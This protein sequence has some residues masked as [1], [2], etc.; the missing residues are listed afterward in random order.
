M[1][2]VSGAGAAGGPP[3]ARIN[4]AISQYGVSDTSNLGQDV[5]ALLNVTVNAQTALDNLQR[6]GHSIAGGG[7]GVSSSPGAFSQGGIDMSGWDA[8]FDEAASVGASLDS[9]ESEAMNLMKSPKKEDQIKGQQMMQA[10]SQ[11]MEA[12][13]KAIQARGDA[14]KHAIQG[15]E[16]H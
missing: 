8:K 9:M 16:S 15:S 13:I 7:G 5:R 3:S 10:V 14:A 6:A 11:I 12:I 1:A 2:G 4:A